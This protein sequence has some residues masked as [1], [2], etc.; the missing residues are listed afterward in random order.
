[1]S[2]MPNMPVTRRAVLSGGIG[3]SIAGG[4]WALS[5]PPSIAAGEISNAK[6]QLTTQG[7]FWGAIDENAT[8]EFANAVTAFQRANA[9]L[10]TGQLSEAVI[11]RLAASPARTCRSQAGSGA[12][13][14]VDL[15]RGILMT[16]NDGEVWR[17]VAL[18]GANGSVVRLADRYVRNDV[19]R[20]RF[21]IRD[22][23]PGWVTHPAGS[24]Y[25]PVRFHHDYAIYGGTS[26]LPTGDV[27]RGDIRVSTAAIAHLVSK[28]HITMA[29]RVWIYQE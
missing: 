22:I 5:A 7:Y 9:M 24:R 12:V 17:T 16:V 29:S 14:E 3:L 15:D 6:R 11:K 20:G 10:V 13:V 18:S 4:L 1:M 28:G 2:E 8:A 23:A 27:T 19:P 26:A 21:R 25:R